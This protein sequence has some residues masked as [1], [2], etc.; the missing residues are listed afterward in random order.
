M[1]TKTYIVLDNRSSSIW[2]FMRDLI[3]FCFI[4]ICIFVSKGDLFWSVFSFIMFILF[5]YGFII[6]TVKSE[7]IFFRSLTMLKAWVDT[8]IY[9]NKIDDEVVDE[10]KRD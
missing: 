1:K 9:L 6:R 5:Y 3:T 4:L 2:Y 7:L 10:N 8:K